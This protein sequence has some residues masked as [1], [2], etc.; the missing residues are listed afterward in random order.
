MLTKVI[1]SLFKR[2]VSLWALSLIIFLQSAGLAQIKFTIS[3]TSTSA[4]T[5]TVTGSGSA[6]TNGNSTSWNNTNGVNQ[7]FGSSSFNFVNSNLNFQTFNLNGDLQL[8][9]GVTPVNFSAIVLDDDTGSD[10]DDFALNVGAPVSMASNTLYTLS[11]SAT[12]DITGKATFAD[13]TTGVYSGTFDGSQSG[14]A[15]FSTSDIIIEV[16][17]G[18]PN[19]A[20]TASN[21]SISGTFGI[22]QE[23][24]GNY[25][26]ADS[27]SD[28]ESG[29]TF[30]W[31]RSD[32]ASGSNRTAIVGATSK[33]YTLTNDDLNK[34]ISF[35]VTPND[36]TVAGAPV[37]SSRQLFQFE[38]PVF[39]YTSDKAIS[40][41]NNGYISL[42][43]QSGISAANTTDDFSIAMWV[44]T[45]AS[46]GALF[47]EF[48]A[49]DSH[50]RNYLSLSGGKL[51]FDQWEPSG[52]S[53]T[54][55]TNINTGEWVHVVYVQESGTRKA[56][57]NGVI[58]AT[59]TNTEAYT[60]NAPNQ[61]Y[62]GYR[63]GNSSGSNFTGEMNEVSWW[64]KTLSTTEI[65]DLYQGT[66]DL[67]DADLLGYI[68][69][70][71]SESTSIVAD[72]GNVG[73]TMNGGMDASD[74]LAGNLENGLM[75]TENLTNGQVISETLIV[76]PANTPTYTLLDAD[77]APVV[78]N[79]D[80]KLELTGDVTTNN[81]YSI[82]FK[83]EL[84]SIEY[85][86]TAE[87]TLNGN[88][89]PTASNVSIAGIM[90]VGETLTGSYDYADAEND[91][92]NGTTFKWYRSDDDQGANKAAIAG[93]S[94][95]T[96]TLTN[97][98]LTKYISFEVTPND[99]TSAGTLVE[100]SLSGAVRVPFIVTSIE[101]QDP[102]DQTI[103]ASEVTFRVTFN[104]SATNV[105]SDDFLLNSTVGG[106]IASVT[107]VTANVYDVTVNTINNVDGT[108]ALQIKGVDGASGSN[109]I[110]RTIV[111]IGAKTIT[112]TNTNDYL[113]QAKLGQTFTATTDNYLTAYTIYPKSGNYS[114][115]GTADLKIYSG[116]ELAGGASL[117]ESQTI[118]LTS[119]TDASGQT[120]M[121]E[122]PVQLTQGEVYSIVMNN[123]TGSGSHALESSTSGNYA[124]GRVI[125]TGTSTSSHTDFDL[126]ID[127]YEGTVT[128]GDALRATAPQTS[129]SYTLEAI[130]V[131]PTAANVTFTGTLEMNEVL[132]GAYDYAD[133]ENDAQSGTTF[134]W[135]RSDDASGTNKTAINGA[136]ANTYT[137]TLA[138]ATKYI[139]FEVTPND[140]NNAGTSVE[141]TLQGPLPSYPPGILNITRQA[142]STETTGS[143]TVVFR[144]KFSDQVTNVDVTDFVLNSTV[145]GA[146]TSV[147]LVSDNS[148]YDV[149]VSGLDNAVGTVSL[150]IKGVDGESGSND[151]AT[152]TANEN[153]E[154]DY[155]GSGDYLNQSFIGQTFTAATSNRLSKITIYPKSGNHSF[156]GTATL[157]I[158]DGDQTQSGTL[159]TSQTVNITNSTDA[160]GQSF[161]IPA[162]PQLTQG[163]TYSFL[164]SNF[165]GSGS[166][167][168]VAS[169][170]AGFANGHVIFTGMNSTSHLTDLDLA[171]Q[172]YEST[173]TAVED[174][175]NTA[176]VTS[177]SYIKEEYVRPPF[178]DW[179]AAFVLEGG[180]GTLAGSNNAGL[181]VSI[182]DGTD[183]R[184]PG[185]APG[186]L[187]ADGD[188]DF[189]VGSFTG[190]IFPM[191]NIG[192]ST[193]PNWEF[194][195]GWIPTIDSLDT[196]PGTSNEGAR[197]VLV[198]IDDD[199]DLDLFVGNQTGWDA[200][201]AA[202]LGVSAAAMNDVVFFRNVGDIGNPV[203][204]FQE[205][206][207][208]FADPDNGTEWFHT[209]YGS[210]TSPSFADLDGDDDLDL[211]V[212]GNDT[213]SY[214]ENIGTKS[215]PE[216]SRKYRENSPFE[217]FSPVTNR[218]GSTLSE[219]SFADIDN[220]GDL[221]L[222]SGNTDGTFQVIMNSGT[223][224]AP[225]F[226]NA[227]K[228]NTHLP[229][230]LK[231]F[232]VGQHSLGRLA[233]LNGDGVLDLVVGS[234]GSSNIGDLGWFSGVRNDPTMVSAV[235]TNNTTITITYSENVQTNGG[236]PTDFI[237]TDCFGNTYAV[238][239][240]AD[241]TAGDTDIVLTVASLESVTGDITITYTNANGEISD[242]NNVQ[243]KTDDTGIVIAAS[244]VVAPT[245]ASATRDSNTEITITFSEN[246]YPLGSNPTDFTVTDSD[247]NTFT[248]GAISDVTQGDDQLLLTVAN[249]STASGDLTITYTNNN[250]EVRDGACNAMATDAT[251][252][253]IAQPDMAYTVSRQTPASE[254]TNANELTFRIDF[255][256]DVR[257]VD[258]TDFALDGSAA[259]DGTIASVEVVTV[260]AEDNRYYDV[261]VSG[262]DDSNGTISV[263]VAGTNGLSGS[264]NILNA[265]VVVDIDQADN[266]ERV[267]TGTPAAQSFQ[268][269]QS[270]PLVAIKIKLSSE[271]QYT[272]DMTLKIREG[273][274]TGGNVIATQDFTAVKGTTSPSITIT[275][276]TPA[277]LTA[278]QSYTFHFD[279][280]NAG[281]F[282]PEGSL[283]NPYA[284]GRQ[285]GPVNAAAYDW[286]FT[287]YTTSGATYGVATSGNTIEAYALD[288]VAPTVTITSSTSLASG[289][290]GAT[291]TFS[292]D[293]S[294]FDVNDISVG[295]GEASNF[296]TTSASVYTATIT[297]ASD[298]A[299]TIDVAADK[300]DDV[301]GNVNTAAT[302][303]SVTNDETAPTVTITSDAG[304]PQSGAF[305]ATFTF[306]EQVSGFTTGDVSLSNAL[307]TNF[308]DSNA[309]V[310]TAT[311]TP[312]ND[313][314][315]T[316]DVNAGAA[317]DGAGND[318]TAA[319][320]LS[321]TNDETAPSVS[322]GTIVGK[323]YGLMDNV[324]VTYVFND[325]VV[326][327]E[328]NGTPSVTIAMGGQNRAAAY[329]SGSGTNTLVFRYTTVAGDI[330]GNGVSVSAINTNGGT[331]Q[332]AAGNDAST[333]I[334]VSGAAG[335]RVDTSAPYMSI[336]SSSNTVSGA[337]TATFTFNEDVS[338]FGLSDISVGNGSA[339]NFN[340]TSAKIYTATITPVADGNVT[341]NVAADK[342]QD[343]GGNGN[344]AASE[345][346]VVN[347]E[348]APAAPIVAS[349][350]TDA[351][352]S[353][354]D[355]LTNDQTLEISGTSEANAS[356]EVFIGGN[357]I[358]NTTA[359]GS[360]NWTYDHTGS[361]LTEA[362]HSITA[363]ATDAAGNESA[364]STALDITVDI[365]APSVSTG[366]IVGKTYGLTENVD[367][368]YV[369]NETV[370]VDE[371]NGT[372]SVTIAMGGQNRAAA[373]N[374]GS[375]TNT[376]VFR[377][378]T[379]AGD[380]DG[381]GVSVSAINTNGG[382]IQ[383]AAGNDASTSISVSGAAGVRVDTSAPYMS[384]TSSSNTVSGA[385]TATFTF[386]EDVSGFDLSDISVAN[387]SASNFNTTSAK[388]YTATITPV[389]DG[390]V[391]VNVA[392][393]KAQ[394]AGGNGNTAASE[395]RVVND[396]T[397]P[398]S[399]VISSISTDAGS[400]ATD[401]LTNDQTLEIS[402]TS[403]ANAS[404]EVFIGGNSIG[405]TTADGSGNWTYD[406]TGSSLTEATHSIT[407]KATDAAGNESTESTA[408]SVTVDVTAPSAPAIR[409]ISNDTGVSDSDG[410]TNDDEIEIHGTAEANSTVEVFIDNN[411]V[412]TID[413]DASG[414]WT[415]DRSRSALAENTYSITA[416]ATDLAGNESSASDAFSLEID[417]TGPVSAPSVGAVGTDRG[418]SDSDF[419][420]NDQTLIIGGN[421][422]S[423]SRVEVF[424]DGTSIGVA[425]TN[426]QTTWLFNHEG[427]TLPAG[428]YSITAKEL[429]DA[430]NYSPASAAKTLVI[431]LTQPRVT[432]TSNANDPQ[433]GEFTA[434]FTFS[435]DV[436]GFDVNDI[437][438][439]NGTAGNFSTT[440]AS[441]YTA[442]ITPS[443]DGQVT[444]GV[445]SNKA[446]DIA[447]NFNTAAAPVNVTNDE[448]APSL[449]SATKDS[450]T[451]ITLTFS[452][453]VAPG[454]N[455]HTSI[456]VYGGN[457][458]SENA[459]SASDGTVGDNQI[460]ITF[461]SLSALLGDF[462]VLHSGGS[463]ITDLAG[464]VY[465]L[466]GTG[467]IIDLDQ[468]A[469]TLV[470]A[471]KDSETQITLTFSEPVKALG[472]NPTDFT[473]EDGNS[474]SFAVQ[475][476]TDGTAEDNKL[477]L[478]VDDLT[479][480]Q[481]NLN[482]TYVN[483]NNVVAD[484]GGNSLGSDATGVNI[485]LNALPTAT[486]VDF[487]GGLIV[488]ETLTGDYTY[489]DSDNDTEDGTT[490][491][492]YR[493]GD[494]NGAN[495]TAIT[496]A[497]ASTYVLTSTDVGK[498]ISF[499]VSP[500]DGI[501]FGA[502]VESRLQGSISKISQT[503][504]FGALA[505]K[506]YGDASF[507]LSAIASSNLGVTYTSSNT[508]VATVSGNTV[509]IIGAGETTITASQS[510]DASYAAATNATQVLTV[511]K[512]AIT[513]TAENKSKV[514]G[515]VNPSFT[516][517]YSGFVNGEDKSVFTSEPTAS[518]V[519]D[520]SSGVGTYDITLTGGVA[521]NY[522]FAANKGTLT[523]SK[524]TLT[525]TADDKSK[526]YGEENPA[527]TITYAGFVNGDAATDIAVPSISTLA[528][529][530]SGVGS[531][532]ITLSGGAADNYSLITNNGSLTIDKATLTA[533]ADDKS[534]VYGEANP[535][536]TISYTGFVNGDTEGDITAPTISTT[537]DATSGVGNY[538]ITLTGGLADNYSLITNNG[539]LTIAKATLTVTAD[540]KSKTYGEA[541]PEL[542]ISYNGFVNGE[543]ESDITVPI[544]GTLADATSGVGNYDI[545]LTGGLADNYSLIATNGS[546]TIAKAT[547]TA[548][549]D[550]KS[551]VYG[552]ANPEFT[553]SYTGFVNGD[554]ESDITA[555]AIGTIA[556]ATS[557]VGTYDI[558]LSRGAA[559]N[560]SLITNNGS[561]TIAKAMLTAT[562]DNKSKTYGDANPE[563]TISYS[564][565]VNGDNST[566]FTAPSVEV[567]A[568]AASDA[569]TYDIT[570]SGGAADNY[571][572]ITNNGSLT[573]NKAVLTVTADDK[574]KGYSQENPEL[575]FTYAGFVNGD[576][577]SDL[578]V[579][580]TISTTA[581]E[582]TAAAIVA[583]TLNGGSDNNYSFNL[584]DGN[585]SII[586]ASIITATTVPTADTYAIGDK[587]TFETS[588][589]LPVTITGTP[590]LPI[591]IGTETKAATL[592]GTVSESNTATFTYTIAEG[593]LDSDGITV[594]STI[595]LNGATIVDEFGT[596]AILTLN[597]TASTA[598]VDVDGIRATPTITSVVSNLTNAA[599]TVTVT[600]DEPVSGLTAEDLD[601]TNGTASNVE[602]VTAG[603]V[604]TVDITPTADGATIVAVAAA[605]VTDAAGNTSV[606]SATGITTTFDGTA[607]TV[608]SIARAEADQLNNADTDAN[609]TV[610]FSEDVTGVDVADFET[611]VTGT[612]T[613]SINSVTVVDAKTYTVNVNGISGE[614]T[615]GLNLKANSSILDAATNAFS[616]AASG[617]VY[618]INWI[619]T[620]IALNSSSIEEN[621]AIGSLV[622]TF[623]TTDQDA[624]DNHTYTLVAGT[625]DTDNAS[626]SINGDQLL[627]AEVF[628][629]ETKDSY[630]IRV[631]TDDGFGGT[632]EQALT[633]TVDN[634][635]E[636]SITI[637]GEE[638]FEETVLG[639]STTKTWTVINDGE[640]EMEVRISNAVTDFSVT[641]SSFVVA[642]G[643]SQEVTVSFMPQAAQ[644]Y[645]GTITFDYD[646][647][648]QS[649]S[650]SGNGVIVTDIDDQ[651]IDEAAISV[652]PN[653]ASDVITLDLTELYGL[654]VDV[655]IYNTTGKPMF[656]KRKVTDSKLRVNVSSYESGVYI[657]R[658]SN[659]QSVVNKK[660]MIKR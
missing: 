458:E 365:T 68:S 369:F 377:Y 1:E 426:A 9:N 177:E 129:E 83:V 221:D 513:A 351:G 74:R 47:G 115:S 567:M 306:S 312:E 142:P 380:I 371:T 111:D 10:Y 409:G 304:S 631:K 345:L 235:K 347:D 559:D 445:T 313:G 316:V 195:T 200:D 423:N 400:S 284:N 109:D 205:I 236:N 279:H 659:G 210:F 425:N 191:R 161:A 146:I 266:E 73:G 188:I 511:N 620:A 81:T 265:N 547:L 227:N 251:G 582:T 554:G 215:V 617:E 124:G 350:S 660:V 548:T 55:D 596:D 520:A 614:G 7:I 216:F 193:A 415:L 14:F 314:T 256:E 185:F 140:G 611:V 379:V 120:F 226:L 386:N 499:E 358:G 586:N 357:S 395:L 217:D 587:L 588:F 123:F 260:G 534:K 583:I 173:V 203:F 413:A 295:N 71:Q 5:I 207:G 257:N 447:G 67:D 218:S 321:V 461:N 402:G 381:N 628:D 471:T 621:S 328:T 156:S 157:S 318:N 440:S 495:K 121:L 54:F 275:F 51:A 436:S 97:D 373:Y 403:E 388:I 56:Y 589:T 491:K 429:D 500:N 504:A 125:F 573:I 564:G 411:S 599:F 13:F 89:V 327:D 519:A 555:P 94:S 2:R 528:D 182:P 80:G 31:Y 32:N 100:S 258:V 132:T 433:K 187:D 655:N 467:A 462:E 116:N 442:K 604:W 219:P 561:L 642:A 3:A 22:G 454:A 248:V 198:D 374:S 107:E 35:E 57:V 392:A 451:Q 497:T 545:T 367:V 396:E 485:Y 269:T 418:S 325:D 410:L 18:T 199:G 603:L 560:Y 108:L 285:Y 26:Y 239:A 343:A 656:G 457:G 49:S 133:A 627:T 38:V 546:L 441:V 489:A 322:T 397:A 390:N 412:G 11:G 353:A 324:D 250:S 141:S 311:I 82:D 536:L 383:D 562:A 483:N 623:T 103:S 6:T 90:E 99:G 422:A 516:I 508:S 475:S 593:D 370:L 240:Q 638:V 117:V 15:N 150:G 41:N 543:G 501:N 363:K 360:G 301:A 539:S 531:Y 632:F 649:K 282:I 553:I 164:F 460:V 503:I 302:Q 320:Q 464:N 291:F 181:N 224:N 127:I 494:I 487:S 122:N 105:T 626:F 262:V 34:Y 557:G 435:E 310:Y 62:L 244:D 268:P 149:T 59:T 636:S 274:G 176:A 540:D 158:Y 171:F 354:T 625:G 654:P 619:P 137:L 167:A 323:T 118:S 393:D 165:S 255:G 222:I 144:V 220:D 270:G 46:S 544:I 8:S 652:Y 126:K 237:V 609:F 264:N 290:F 169:T 551:K 194:Q 238:S 186:D 384:I 305:T 293:V 522:S 493:S 509:S 634:V 92:E 438:V 496:G 110:K 16:L 170:N 569:G 309:P 44:K 64:S 339:S 419:I 476:I 340:T 512:A 159:I 326:V 424:I 335:V 414:N 526:T 407:A 139:S 639:F 630:S 131:A 644:A 85:T 155:N 571:S 514:Y 209:N 208:L 332:D 104:G 657:L 53:T 612:A 391:T 17:L 468:I 633:I 145:N 648:S 585:L 356:V 254:D 470:S 346:R 297:P 45:T 474:S 443:A 344:T 478:T 283:S 607:P 66:I 417:L 597:N 261:V 616:T 635:L 87:V 21:V 259:G 529:A 4:T 189:L 106:A 579:E 206:D 364:T 525:A 308:D 12:F 184:L 245:M 241:G 608:S 289:A 113:D 272:G 24:T 336:T 179:P 359:D 361:S 453:V 180:S 584:V 394:D 233:D 143:T 228:S 69:F 469:P 556:D 349:I 211:I 404:V 249:L 624:T 647:G 355:N 298:G 498:Y 134:Q 135:Y 387:G 263:G 29:S 114:F 428:T 533:T 70:N 42:N 452:E 330:D 242:L 61:F 319:T 23:L 446:T 175:S 431:D 606:A 96:Y 542:T 213:I 378:T 643:A 372:P 385:F 408:L 86:S 101:R 151:I 456:T 398:A 651:L 292:E 77:D 449:V 243:Q 25:T 252:I 598:N 472:T 601:I 352:S 566:D 212:M 277:E 307:I 40:F 52:G 148:T 202:Q 225:E 401:N 552:D 278:G 613:A 430:G 466:D 178:G 276:D 39:R 75:V 629:F 36:G 196:K 43:G 95:K 286:T 580:P 637:T 246:V 192:T 19:S 480:A 653:P 575:T 27:D 231:N 338:G 366:T 154:T 76:N 549:A 138:E 463:T 84:Q 166:H 98:D 288:N 183:K 375:G 299:V 459:V 479:N 570:L 234:L 162:L 232:D 577:A 521:G 563:L 153:L 168:I 48:I 60:G 20:P 421:A 574:V 439:T 37:E 535:E 507:T 28:A 300:A 172:V 518:T 294:G 230:V 432:I 595:D 515:E 537:A 505:A 541:N 448:T 93:A 434:T 427:T 523:I 214:A 473:V 646:G 160:G 58:E 492:W 79:N 532:S 91:A 527:F 502:A 486:N 267:N 622:G 530:T 229:D 594:G 484:F 481:L 337:F 558:T 650:V 88:T 572:L 590:S 389:A 524:A 341:V 273:D 281:Q 102:T 204:E 317:Q 368:T 405:N 197:P 578:D 147:E 550:D 296:N 615:I 128:V 72:A 247:N 223:A 645:S 517:T 50:T 591:T 342:A 78:I 201:R 538:D 331:I 605:A 510:G 130:N 602:V 420:T 506:T 163:N 444:V 465:P 112:Q 303:L 450:D 348:T 315:V 362:T 658:F 253:V 333:S 641:P 565:L 376:L 382:T 437:S 610:T 490:F 63:G 280:A 334:S 576:D 190:K 406:H 33:T 600:Y 592:S 30:K 640:L 271:S 329:H 482:I 455:G 65:A 152:F 416:K 568:N 581:D 119:S 287:T 174:L 477:I 136:T 399:P 488:G 618:T